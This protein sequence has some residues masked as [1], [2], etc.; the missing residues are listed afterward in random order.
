MIRFTSQIQSKHHRI[1]RYPLKYTF[2]ET[3]LQKDLHNTRHIPLYLSK[4]Y[5]LPIP[6]RAH[7]AIINCSHKSYRV[8]PI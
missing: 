2:I 5:I 4:H 3:N 6:A 7:C 8:S 1:V